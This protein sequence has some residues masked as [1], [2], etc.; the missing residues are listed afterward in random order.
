MEEH[1]W[2]RTLYTLFCGLCMGSA[3]IVPGVSGGTIAFVMGFYEELLRSLESLNHEALLALVQGRWGLASQLIAWPFLV[4][5]LSGIGIAI[6]LLAQLIDTILN[7]MELRTLLYAAFFGMIAASVY[8]CAKQLPRWRKRDVIALILGTLLAFFLTGIEDSGDNSAVEQ[9][10]AALPTSFQPKVAH[11]QTILNYDASAGILRDM[12]ADELEVLY[13]QGVLGAEDFV[14]RTSDNVKIPLAS[15]VAKQVKTAWINPWI[16]FCGALAVCALLLPGISGSYLLQM[17]GMYSAVIAALADFTSG[18]VHLSFNVRAALV[19]ANLAAGIA[20]GAALFSHVVS[21]LLA[22]YRSAT[23]AFLTGCMVGSLR[24][25][26]PFYTYEY[27][28]EPIHLLRGPRLEP[29]TLVYPSFDDPLLWWG[30]ASAFLA[31][32]IVCF[33]EKVAKKSDKKE[34]LA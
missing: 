18:L 9:Y 13:V 11:D 3:D 1:G 32:A 26:W 5:L 30:L 19:L 17:L 31:F 14:E 23:I 20:V 16:I 24:T 7:H 34:E 33:L 15:V 25:L 29:I 27:I 10:H 6:A 2:R 4:P 8:Y 28:L 21:W 22:R 12:T